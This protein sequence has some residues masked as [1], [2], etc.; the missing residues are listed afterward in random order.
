M[1]SIKVLG[2]GPGHPDYCLPIVMKEMR[3]CDVLVGGKRQ[4]SLA[5][6]EDRQDVILFSM[7]IEDMMRKIQSVAESR[8]VGI[9]VSG[10]AGFY[11]LL[12]ALRRWFKAAELEVYPG[13]SS[14]QYLFSQLSLPWDQAVVGSLHGRD[15]DWKTQVR[16]R[17][18]V[19]LLTDAHQSPQWIA[20]QIIEEG[21]QDCW[22]IVGENLSYPEERIEKLRP[23]DLV[24]K[25]Y[26][27]LSVV[28]IVYE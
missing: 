12:T 25:E 6:P 15:W 5:K 18:T 26:E 23:K 7:P 27:S 2:I 1:K 17:K 16:K 3:T 4:L 8:S 20:N 13:I 19:G 14:L 9:L 24:T 21:L 10:D 22:L 11:S 28:V